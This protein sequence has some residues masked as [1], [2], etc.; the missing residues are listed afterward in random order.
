MKFQ[1]YIFFVIIREY[2][3]LPK[4]HMLY[5]ITSCFVMNYNK[6]LKKEII[7]NNENSKKDKDYL[8]ILILINLFNITIDQG[9][10][11]GAGSASETELSQT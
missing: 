5:D 4:Y 2:D 7:W 3:R 8:L 1:K 9:D 6:I 10:R 11:P